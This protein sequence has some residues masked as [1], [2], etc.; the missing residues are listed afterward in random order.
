MNKYLWA[1]LPVVL[2]AGALIGGVFIYRAGTGEETVQKAS[3]LPVGTSESRPIPGPK[4]EDL[5]LQVLNGGGVAGNASKAKSFLEG[6]GYK[7]VATANADNY[8]YK[9]TIITVKK[10]KKD[11]GDLLAKDLVKNYE[12]TISSTFLNEKNSFDAVVTIGLK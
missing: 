4:R 12:A 3:S 1:L 8:D 6:V 7:D 10:S 5:K 2:I 11:Y 9:T